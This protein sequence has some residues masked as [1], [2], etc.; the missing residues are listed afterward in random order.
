MA[1]TTDDLASIDTAIASGIKRVTFADG[2][3]TEYQTTDSML[4]ARAMMVSSINQAANVA[5]GRPRKRFAA[6][7]SGL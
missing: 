3:T 5:A 4:A 1:F 6:F 7:G 2:R